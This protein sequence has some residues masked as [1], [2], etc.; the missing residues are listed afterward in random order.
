MKY[1]FLI[2][3]IL[4][5]SSASADTVFSNS[6][7]S[8][9]TVLLKSKSPY[10]FN[11]NVTVQQGITLTI[12]KGVKL[13]FNSSSMYIHRGTLMGKDF[14]IESKSSNYNFILQCGSCNLNIE[15]VSVTGIPRSFLSAWNESNVTLSGIEIDYSGTAANIV[16]V[17][18]FNKTS[19]TISSSTFTRLTKALE[20]FSF[21][22]STITNSFFSYNNHAIYTFDSSV[23][24]HESDF[25]FNHIAIEFFANL[26][27]LPIVDAHNNW[28]GQASF[29]P[30][31][32][33]DISQVQQSDINAIVGVVIY[34]P[35]SL[36]SHKK[37][38]IT[39]GL[40]NVLFLPGLMGSRLYI[41]DGFEN[42][43]WEPNRNKDVTRLFLN[44]SGRSIEGSIYTRDIIS[45]TNIAG[46][47]TNLDQAIYKDFEVYMNGLVKNKVINNW[48]AAPYD[49]RYSPD[50]ILSDG[51]ITGD[52]KQNFNMNLVAEV[53]AL[54]KNSKSKKV[55][56]ITH[57]NGGLVGKQ[58]MIELK[59]QKL[60]T[61]IDKIIFVAMPEYGTPQAITSLLYGHEQSIANGL[62]L[63]ASI[64]HELGVNMP[65]AYSLLPTEKYFA[66]NK[67]IPIDGVMI[68]N[69]AELQSVFPQKGTINS[70]LLT[71]A[72]EF[73]N[74]LDT[75]IPPITIPVYQIVGTGVLT[76]SGISKDSESKPFPQY[77]TTGDGTVQDMY[78]PTSQL[79]NR[80][81]KVFIAD[82]HN[83]KFKHTNIMNFDVTMKYL[84]LLIRKNPKEAALIPFENYPVYADE[85]ALFIFS[86]ST[87]ELSQKSIHMTRVEGKSV[88]NHKP[89]EQFDFTSAEDSGGRFD[90]FNKSIQYISNVPID[91]V[92]ILDSKTDVF[93]LSIYTKS[94]EGMR[95]IHYEDIT[96][97]QDS[98]MSLDLTHTEPYINIDLPILHQN[99]QTYPKTATS[100]PVNLVEKITFARNEIKISKISQYIKD[101]YIR[102]LDT[103]LKTKDESALSSLKK[104]VEEG[105]KAIDRFTHNAALKQRYAKLKQEYVYIVHLLK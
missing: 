105:I 52:G 83:S 36:A 93:D 6:L 24:I 104:S 59:K 90:L 73:R 1:V 53:M 100:T 14:S 46:G 84:D 7:I 28:W 2:L 20:I 94:V 62:I 77:S 11:Q 65:S 47:V 99:I 88:L 12:E 74:T 55:T 26:E 10:I 98:I 82:L 78:N 89:A 5:T 80:T 95:E 39:E 64:A 34:S 31:Y 37:G 79:F 9:N 29:P 41:K 70:S 40:S 81:G 23:D 35:W 25:E 92:K 32:R 71:K 58:L 102:R 17:Q 38:E 96:L 4:Y 50:T 68:G 67:A 60:E 13:I 61:L 103:I 87:T 33:D 22:T 18:A 49:W 27:V 54:A 21:S 91:L 63:R 76:V 45:K 42:Q 66:D 101:R 56:L 48:K 15:H 57:S 19:L 3:I 44:S 51:I 16:G 75:W 86:A 69:K 97:F 8:E 30:I 85:F 43:L 72:N